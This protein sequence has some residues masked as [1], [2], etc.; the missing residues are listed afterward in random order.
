MPITSK[1]KD[2]FRN[3]TTE[4]KLDL[5]QL[6]MGTNEL[7]VSLTLA[8]MKI[9]HR[10]LKDNEND[11]RSVYKRYAE[12]IESL[13]YHMLDTLQLAVATWKNHQSIATTPAEW[14]SDGG[15]P[16]ESK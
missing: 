15:S 4:D 10:E 6:L 2:L 16:K 9:I 5:F 3:P 13:R 1:H 8:L 12:T 14:F 11:D 7:S